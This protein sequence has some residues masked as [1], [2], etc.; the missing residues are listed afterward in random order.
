[1]ALASARTARLQMRHKGKRWHNRKGLTGL[2]GCICSMGQR[3]GQWPPTF[4]SI[5]QLVQYLRLIA[6]RQPLLAHGHSKG[7][8]VEDWGLGVLDFV[9]CY[10]A[11]VP[12][13]EDRL[14]MPPPSC[15]TCTAQQG[16]LQPS[17]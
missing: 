6:D 15:S 8:T 10:A 4:R 9:I 17:A 1:M 7:W 12:R 13:D 3:A 11:A 16:E 2:G 14:S 5:G